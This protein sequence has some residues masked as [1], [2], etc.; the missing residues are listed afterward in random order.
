VA[1]AFGDVRSLHTSCKMH[2]IVVVA[3]YD[4]RAAAS[5]AATLNG[6]LILGMSIE[7]QLT[8]LRDMNDSEPGVGQVRL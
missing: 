2:G 1:Q 8:E 6:T 7:L 4:A 5:A 3:Y